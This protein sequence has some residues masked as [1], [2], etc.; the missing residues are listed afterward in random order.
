MLNQKTIKALRLQILG[1]LVGGLSPTPG[2]AGSLPDF[3]EATAPENYFTSVAGVTSLLIGLFIFIGFCVHLAHHARTNPRRKRRQRR[4]HTQCQLGWVAALT[5]LRSTN[6]I[7]DLPKTAAPMIPEDV[8]ATWMAVFAIVLVIGVIAATYWLCRGLDKTGSPTAPKS[9]ER[10]ALI[11]LIRRLDDMYPTLV[12]LKQ[13]P[14]E[15]AAA[16]SPY[17][18]I[19]R[20]VGRSRQHPV[21]PQDRHG[22][23]TGDALMRSAP[24]S[25]HSGLSPRPVHAAMIF[26]SN[27]MRSYTMSHHLLCIALKGLPIAALLLSG[28]V[29][30]ELPTDASDVLPDGVTSDGSAASTLVTIFAFFLKLAA[31]AVMIISAIAGGGYLLNSFGEAQRDR[32]GMGRFGITAVAVLVMIGLVVVFGLLAVE[33][34][35]GLSGLSASA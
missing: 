11:W 8:R 20:E 19:A 1:L 22:T 13:R 3:S 35:D 6:A 23:A 32:G 26:F 12:A 24:L 5:V 34:A 21:R 7:A 30:A 18:A 31:Y 4:D 16:D 10:D 33:W 14:V 9:D 2:L 25:T 29:L 17:V 28:E 15:A 27:P